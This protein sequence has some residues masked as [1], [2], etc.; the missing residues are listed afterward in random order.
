M[1]SAFS[2][3]AYLCIWLVVCVLLILPICK[4]PGAETTQMVF[5]NSESTNYH[6]AVLSLVLIT[7]ISPIV[8]IGE[9]LISVNNEGYCRMQYGSYHADNTAN[10]TTPG[11][12]VYSEII[13]IIATIFMC[14]NHK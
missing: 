6:T 4:P 9:L 13:Y 14:H 3:H 10:D 12:H 2:G 1:A 11:V 8:W 7:V 5:Y